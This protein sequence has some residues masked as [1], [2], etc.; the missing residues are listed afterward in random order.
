MGVEEGL[1]GERWY[2]SLVYVQWRAKTADEL[3]QCRCEPSD[4]QCAEAVTRSVRVA[5]SARE[6]DDTGSLD[7]YFSLK[8]WLNT[9]INTY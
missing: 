8:Y 6:S 1:C 7:L 9:E 2:I 5:R 4:G 3:P